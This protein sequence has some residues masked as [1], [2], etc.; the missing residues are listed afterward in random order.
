MLSANKLSKFKQVMRNAEKIH[1]KANWL[2]MLRNT[3]RSTNAG[4]LTIIPICHSTKWPSIRGLSNIGK[5][6]TYK[7]G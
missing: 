5:P 4:Y 3:K 1:K 7:V 6:I 2:K